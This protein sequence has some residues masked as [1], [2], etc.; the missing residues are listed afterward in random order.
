MDLFGM[1][2][3]E[4]TVGGIATLLTT[5]GGGVWLTIKTIGKEA[6]RRLERIESKHEDCI[7]DRA[8]DREEIGGLRAT[9]GILSKTQPPDIREEVKKTL[10][11]AQRRAEAIE[12]T[13][14]TA[15]GKR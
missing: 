15:P 12:S 5:I 4:T 2:I 1:E 9:V 3:S 11:E 6:L 8:V 14:S 10:D 13:K 7:K